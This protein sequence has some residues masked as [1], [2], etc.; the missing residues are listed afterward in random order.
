[1]K[2]YSKS[3]C[4]LADAEAWARAQERLIDRSASGLVRIES[5]KVSEAIQ[6]YLSEHVPKLKRQNEPK[7]MLRWWERRLGDRQLHLVRTVELIDLRNQLSL[8][9]KLS[10]RS[11]SLGR[12][13]PLLGKDGRPVLRS[14]KTVHDYFMY[15]RTVFEFAVR[16]W[17]WLETSPFWG[18]KAIKV[19][20]ARHRFLSDFY[21]L[22]PGEKAPRHWDS[23]S[24]QEKCD[25]SLC[26]PRAYELPRLIEALKVQETIYK[27]G[28][29]HIGSIISS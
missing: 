12:R 5:R 13:Q 18:V 4:L 9:P 20:N 8:E 15:M 21:H 29:K 11:D 2:P 25:A 7:S 3:F 26:F 22:W 14:A 1:M 28:Y 6:R 17:G 16:E 10:Q 23:L 24:G 19:E 27:S